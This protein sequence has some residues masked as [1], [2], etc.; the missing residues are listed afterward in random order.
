MKL[1]K[2]IFLTSIMGL[3]ASSAIAEQS[4]LKDSGLSKLNLHFTNNTGENLDL[5]Y[6]GMPTDATF[7]F[8]NIDQATDTNLSKGKEASYNLG[9]QLVGN[10]LSSNGATFVMNDGQEYRLNI[11]KNTDPGY[12]EM[13]ITMQAE[14]LSSDKYFSRGCNIGWDTK[15]EDFSLDLNIVFGKDGDLSKSTFKCSPDIPRPN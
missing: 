8:K 9:M 2:T 3:S 4:S 14:P 10:E 13:E 11:L 6:Q 7:A 1:V 15:A 5:K 12:P